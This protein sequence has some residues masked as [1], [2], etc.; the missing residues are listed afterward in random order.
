MKDMRRFSGYV[1]RPGY[2]EE[3]ELLYD[4]Y[5]KLSV[6]ALVDRLSVGDALVINRIDDIDPDAI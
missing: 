6:L 5:K 4:S 3:D 2:P 1:V